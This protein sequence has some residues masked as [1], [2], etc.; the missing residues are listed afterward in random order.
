MVRPVR[1][2]AMTASCHTPSIAFE[3]KTDWSKSGLIS[4]PSGAAARMSGSAALT[5]LTTSS[6]EAV[7]FLSTRISTEACPSART[8]LTC[9]GPPSRT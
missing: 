8:T 9:G 1:Q 3:T 5:L 6:V 7:P 2:A 4:I